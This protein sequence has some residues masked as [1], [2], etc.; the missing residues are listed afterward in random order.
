M[1]SAGPFAVA[2]SGVAAPVGVIADWVG[3]LSDATWA[4]A[5]PAIAQL[6]AAQAVPEAR[7]DL[8]DLKPSMK[9][10]PENAILFRIGDDVE[11]RIRRL[12]HNF[13]VIVHNRRA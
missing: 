12:R 13:C 7:T 5:V 6:S 9:A 4:K 1:M 2:L 10:S 8:N 11:T 3:S